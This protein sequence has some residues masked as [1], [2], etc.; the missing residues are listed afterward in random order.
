[1]LCY[2]TYRLLTIPPPASPVE[3]YTISVWSSIWRTTCQPNTDIYYKLDYEITQFQSFHW[4]SY[5]WRHG[6][7]AIILYSTNMS[8]VRI[9]TI[10]PLAFVGNEMIVAARPHAP[11]CLFNTAH[12]QRRSVYFNRSYGSTATLWLGR[13]S[14]QECLT[15]KKVHVWN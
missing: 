2:H 11:R 15:L 3:L 9:K 13:K 4:L 1:M 8:S 7:R 12:I 6:L 10:I 14:C 5:H